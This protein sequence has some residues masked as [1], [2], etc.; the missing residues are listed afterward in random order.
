VTKIRLVFASML[1]F[2]L[3]GNVA[4]QQ[5]SL[6]QVSSASVTQV[7]SGSGK[8]NPPAPVKQPA[9]P[10]PNLWQ[11]RQM[12]TFA[13]DF[14]QLEHFRAANMALPAISKGQKR[15]VFFGDSITAIWKLDQSFPNMGYINRGIGGQTTSQ[16]LLRYRQDVLE[17]KPSVVVIL[18]GTNDIAGNT[19]AIPTKDIEANLQTMA[20][21]A[22]LQGLR[23]VF[24]SVTPVNN[25]S[26]R[27]KPLY[28][29]RPIPRILEL[30]QWMKLYSATHKGIYY[31]DYY[32]SMLDKAGMMAEGLA[33]D[34]LHPNDA[35]FEVMAPLAQHA[36]ESALTRKN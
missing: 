18:A 34:G 32:D 30:N 12:E 27:A 4:A 9:Y 8:T 20:E 11:Q 29:D 5:V 2:S 19:G 33:R 15:I 35:G 28:D 3:V 31:L 26:E 16:M 6:L 1:V 21:L 22:G 7:A 23:V 14:G 36:I 24:S 25:Y 17:L 13:N 10:P